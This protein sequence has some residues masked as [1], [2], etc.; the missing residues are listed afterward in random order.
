VKGNYMLKEIIE[1]HNKNEAENKKAFA[2]ANQLAI[3]EVGE[4]SN[5]DSEDEG[6]M[7]KKA[8]SSLSNLNATKINSKLEKF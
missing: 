8:S 6:I 5:S 7:T 3:P 1:I 2:K 4:S